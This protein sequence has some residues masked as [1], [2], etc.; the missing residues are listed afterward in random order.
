M[1]L[2]LAQ[3][4]S[5]LGEIM[6]ALN[7]GGDSYT[8]SNGIRYRR[9]YLAD[10]VASDYGRALDIQR[11]PQQ[12][13]ILYQTERYSS[14]TFGYTVSMPSSDADYV[15]WL[16]FSEVWF[17]APGQKVFDIGLNDNVV[18]ENLDIFAK[19]GRGVAHDE[20]VPFQIRQNKLIINGKA[21]PFNSE[22]RVDFIKTDRDNP[23]IN[24]IVIMKG[25]PDQVPKLL[26]YQPPKQNAYE[27]F[28]EGDEELDSDSDRP[29]GSNDDEN[30][31]EDEEEVKMRRAQLRAK[32]EAEQQQQSESSERVASKRRSAPEPDEPKVANPYESDETSYL[33]PILVAI[34]AFIPLLFC[35]CKL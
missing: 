13:K 14:E 7:A 15:L 31:E 10:G 4:T 12:D 9:D 32:R 35:L 19:V 20:I 21:H 17:N 26:P 11:V 22:L 18:V 28:E 5:A 30:E 6:F 23:K 3:T 24:A 1:I 25:T 16:K 27:D 2:N 29:R 34:G 8:D 33:I